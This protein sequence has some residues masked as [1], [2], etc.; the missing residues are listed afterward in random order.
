[1][2]T[3]KQVAPVERTLNL[4]ASAISGQGTVEASGTLDDVLGVVKTV[5]SVAAPILGSL[6]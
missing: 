4:N 1:M 2:N 6:I 5:G 3:P